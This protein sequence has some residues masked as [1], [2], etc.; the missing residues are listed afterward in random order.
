MRRVSRRSI[1]DSAR[2]AAG[3][4]FCRPPVHQAIIAR[5]AGFLPLPT[6]GARALDVGCGAGRSTA[7]LAPV[8]AFRV[9]LE[10][11]PRMLAHSG[12]VAP[13]AR[14]V[15]GRAEHLPF[16]PAS[17]DIV[18]AAGSLNYVDLDR[19]L[20]EAARVLA[21]HGAL[22]V[23]DFSAA[24][25][26]RGDG[27]LD[28]WF[29]GFARQHPFPP[30]YAMDIR[31]TDFPAFG[32]RLDRYVPLQVA[33]PMTLPSYLDY[34][35]SETNVELAIAGGADETAIR[36]WCADGLRPI[37]ADGA[38]EILFDAYATVILRG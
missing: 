15:S 13:G 12:A 18:A 34:A 9:G 28:E 38:R 5:V 11:V 22:L 1:Y 25:T 8:A 35:M 32:F 29:D 30:G 21:R 6:T 26:M 37:F 24:R 23:Y 14:F 7:A 27:R 2:M 31:A 33:M 19:F 3:Y 10:P 17:F 4:A 36:D 20:P 16:A